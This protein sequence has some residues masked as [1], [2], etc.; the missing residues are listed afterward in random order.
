[1]ALVYPVRLQVRRR[2]LERYSVVEVFVLII[3]CLDVLYVR[4]ERQGM[5]G[6]FSLDRCAH[7]FL[8]QVVLK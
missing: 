7:A 6:F 1:M 4:V 2:S 5:F 3:I 8:R